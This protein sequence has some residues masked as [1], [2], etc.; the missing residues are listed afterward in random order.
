MSLLP[1]RVYKTVG[2]KEVLEKGR[3]RFVT[4]L[5]PGGVGWGWGSRLGL[6][7]RS[8]DVSISDQI[9]FPSSTQ[10]VKHTYIGY[11]KNSGIS[12]T[13]FILSGKV[14]CLL[15][16]FRVS[17]RSFLFFETKWGECYRP[18]YRVILQHLCQSEA[19]EIQQKVPF[20]TLPSLHSVNREVLL[21]VTGTFHRA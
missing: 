18:L 16:Y 12:K 6:C 8:A 9:G 7:N 2:G 3:G 4:K 15:P 17:S 21:R 5:F 1:V 14:P 20:H 13:T 10:G 11:T 19:S